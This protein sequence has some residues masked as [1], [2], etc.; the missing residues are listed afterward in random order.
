[1][2]LT[3]LPETFSGVMVADYISVGFANNKA[4]P[5]FAVAQAKT[6]SIFHQAIYTTAAGQDASSPETEFMTADGDV[7][8][9]NAHSDHGP[10]EYLDQDHEIPIS[11]KRPP[12]R[13]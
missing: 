10:M 12:Q 8:I 3:W 11:G 6:G 13:D 5:V 9:A 1:M 7:P 2:K 4:F